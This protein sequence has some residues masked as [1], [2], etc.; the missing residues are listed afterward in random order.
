VIADEAHMIRTAEGHKNTTLQWLGA[1]F[2]LLMTATPWLNGFRDLLAYAPLI[3]PAGRDAVWDTIGAN[4]PA[5]RERENLSSLTKVLRG[6]TAR[7]ELLFTHRGSSLSDQGT[8]KAQ[9]LGSPVA[10]IPSVFAWPILRRR[11]MTN[12]S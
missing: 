9:I 7:P 12:M 3:F 2:Y 11:Q 5:D 1:E 6:K 4:R 10:L 8:K